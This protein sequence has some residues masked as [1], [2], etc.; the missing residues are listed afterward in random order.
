MEITDE[1][2]VLVTAEVEKAVKNIKSID[3][4]AKKTE[5]TFKTLGST[6]AQVFA[7]KEIISFGSESL[8]L[9]REQKKQLNVL[10]STLKATEA[11]AWTSAEQIAEMASSLQNLTNYGDEAIIAMN[12]ILLGFRNIKGDTFKEATKA[13]LDMSQVMGMDLKSAAQVVGKAL[14]DPV[15]GLDSLKRQGFNFT[16]SQKSLLASLVKT[17]K[18][19]EA[20]KIILDELSGTYGGAAEAAADAGVQL[21]NTWGDLK[22]DVGKQIEEFF[23]N[24]EDGLRSLM[25]AFLDMDEGTKDFITGM[26][27]VIAI[28]VPVIAAINGIKLAATS[29]MAHPLIAATAGIVA[30]I[31]AIAGAINACVHSSENERAEIEKTDTAAKKLLES[32]SSNNEQ[33]V[34][35]AKTTRELIDLYPELRGKITAYK[36]TLEEAAAAQKELNKQK[37]IDN[38]TEELKKLEK[39]KKEYQGYIDRI[40]EA[41]LEIKYLQETTAELFADNSNSKENLISE[42]KDLILD[43]QESVEEAEAKINKKAN[44]IKNS[45]AGIGKTLKGNRIIVDLEVETNTNPPGGDNTTQKKWQEWF[46]EVT[47]IKS[48]SFSTGKQAA[49]LYIKQSE[50]V[51]K[52]DTSLQKA[53]LGKDFK[54]SESIESEL[55]KVKKDIE[56]LLSETDIDEPFKLADG[57][58]KDLIARYREL[59]SQFKSASIREELEAMRQQTHETSLTTR[60]LLEEKLKDI[61]ITEAEKEE[62]IK[63]YEAINKTE[64]AQK[65][66]DDVLEEAFTGAFKNLIQGADDLAECFGELT[67]S[68]AVAGINASLSGFETFGKSLGEGADGAESL[69][70]ALVTMHKELLNNL[71]TL[72]L[73]AGLNLIAHNPSMWAIGLGFIAA[74]GATAI[75]SG[76]VNG[77]TEGSSEA[78]ALGGV[79]GD[80][81]Y[82]AF[83]KG[84]TFTNAIVTSPTFFK[85]AKGSGFGTGLMGEAGPEA[86]MPL[87]RGADGSLGVTASGLGY[88]DVQ[89]NIPVTVYSDEPVKVNDT[90]DGSGQRKIEIMVGSMINRHLSDGSADRVLKSR[91][92][93][94]AQGV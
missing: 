18:Q 19:A 36:T 33:K 63:L 85:F 71:P 37:I 7:A 16:E 76:F 91:Y 21:A 49:E 5:N 8:S 64:N 69:R 20:Q 24:A 90:T 86:I 34:L 48:G 25:Q 17:G 30:G 61:D 39:L 66:F 88:G 6:I 77:R 80:D 56:K 32:Q 42:K 11:D 10:A 62:Y 44:E 45:L 38:A 72:F 3:D 58:I 89:V 2:K 92:G 28:S 82:S 59:D 75:I 40:G 81:G 83:A 1:L 87:S 65:S 60:E 22:E 73:N 51:F 15:K 94:K 70:E 74:A 35:D 84:G 78:N 4:T 52:N 53:L 57:S 9:W 79:Y 47:G 29:L 54:L 26:G 50:E 31:G 46:E 27:A 43:L 14:D 13:I 93:L 67:A 68:I 23:G 55:S 12:N 41:E